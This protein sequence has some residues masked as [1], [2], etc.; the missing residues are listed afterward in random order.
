MEFRG[1][2]RMPRTLGWFSP[3]RPLRG[4]R[5]EK[6]RPVY[7]LSSP[8]RFGRNRLRRNRL[9]C[10]NFVQSLHRYCGNDRRPEDALHCPLYDRALQQ[11]DE[12]KNIFHIRRRRLP[13]RGNRTIGATVLIRVE[14]SIIP[15]PR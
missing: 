5:K 8:K 11:P 6:T 1:G 15:P 12:G 3:P 13:Q 14:D 4:R 2:W 9:R 7:F 10:D